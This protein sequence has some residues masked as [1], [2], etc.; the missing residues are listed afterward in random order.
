MVEPLHP[1]ITI[2]RQCALLGL[3]RSAYDYC[4]QPI[5]VAD[6][7]L[8]R[9]LDEEYTRHPFYG[10]RRLRDWLHGHGHRIGRDRV[11]RLMREMGLEAIAPKPRVRLPD[12]AHQVYPYLLRSLDILRPDQVWCSDITYLRLRRVFAYLTVVMDWFSRYV[13]AYEV[14]LSLE[15]DFCVRALKSALTLTT[16]EIC[17]TDQGS[18]Y[19]SEAFITVLQK[20]EVQISMDGKGRCFDNI[21]VER[22]WRTVKYEEVY[23]HEYAD[24]WDARRQLGAYFTFYNDERKHTGIGNRTPADVYYGSQAQGVAS[25]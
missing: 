6:R 14:S 12:R 5:S 23:L 17:N 21:M 22:L 24:L 9:L 1:H 19:T 2:A 8:M 20:A 7:Q 15:S 3:S 4:P 18:Q 10:A 13:L 25:A 16:P 11:R